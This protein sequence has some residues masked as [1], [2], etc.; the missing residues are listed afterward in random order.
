MPMLNVNGKRKRITVRAWN[1]LQRQRAVARHY[2][3]KR[4]LHIG[5]PL[6]WRAERAGRMGQ[7]IRIA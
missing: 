6:L 5:L 7:S 2:G 3:A 1:A 4:N